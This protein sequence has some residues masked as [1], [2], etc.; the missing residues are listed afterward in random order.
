MDPVTGNRV[1]ESGATIFSD[2][3]KERVTP[4]IVNKG[5]KFFAKSVK[6]VRRN[7]SNG[8][9]NG[10]A[11]LFAKVFKVES[12]KHTIFFFLYRLGF[13]ISRG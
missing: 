3:L 10:S 4:R 2:E 1:M 13:D 11:P 5:E 6:F 12:L 8:L 9:S 7:R